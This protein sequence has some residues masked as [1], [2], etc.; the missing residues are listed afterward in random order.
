MKHVGFLCLFSVFAM[1]PVQAGPPSD[2][3]HAMAQSLSDIRAAIAWHGAACVMGASE[4]DTMD[5][6]VSL[7]GLAEETGVALEQITAWAA[8]RDVEHS[9]AV[10]VLLRGGEPLR[11]PPEPF[12]TILRQAQVDCQDVVRERRMLQAALDRGNVPERVARTPGALRT[13]LDPLPFDFDRLTRLSF[14]LR[15]VDE[16]LAAGDYTAD[17]EALLQ[18]VSGRERLTLDDI[19][20]MRPLYDAMPDP[21]APQL[22]FFEPMAADLLL[23][24]PETATDLSAEE[25]AEVLARLE[26]DPTGPFTRYFVGLLIANRDR[27][28]DDIGF[29]W[30]DNLVE[31]SPVDPEAATVLPQCRR[32]ADSAAIACTVP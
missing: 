7:S 6:P 31:A 25:M 26:A 5:G 15:G 23:P 8:G 3:P 32:V 4:I 12:L 1:G 2:V 11:D 14:V 28:P 27:L 24:N 9:I 17:I 10:D 30:S 16:G 22:L 20:Q 29:F 21:P 19:A 18:A 13:E